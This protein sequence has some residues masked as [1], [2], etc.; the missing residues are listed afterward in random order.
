M[1]DIDVLHYLTGCHVVRVWAVGAARQRSHDNVEP[2]D[3]VDEGAAV[4]MQFANGIVGTFAV[5]DNV[6]SPYGWESA[7]GDNPLYSP[8]SMPVD[9]Y[10][11]F[12]TA[13]TLSAPE[14]TLWSYSADDA[15]RLGLEVGWNIPMRR[16]TLSAPSVIPFQQ[17]AE[18]LARVVKGIELPRC[19]GD[20]GLAAVKVCEAVMEALRVGDGIPIDIK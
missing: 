16:E 2:E 15:K 9:T 8:A 1:H 20:D 19:S 11:I 10:R 5:N 4:M 3:M 17:Q 13:G 12:G 6:A 7:T 14:G 18:H